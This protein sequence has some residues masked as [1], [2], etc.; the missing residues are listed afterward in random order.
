MTMRPSIQSQ[1]ITPSFPLLESSDLPGS[2]DWSVLEG[3]HCE[4][5]FDE[6]DDRFAT[7][8]VASGFDD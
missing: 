3:L 7:L 6:E 8:N 5:S 2:E 4:G 1:M